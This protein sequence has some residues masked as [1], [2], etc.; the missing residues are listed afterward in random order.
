MYR[1]QKKRTNRLRGQKRGN[2]RREGRR[3]P[4]LEHPHEEQSPAQAAQLVHVHGDMLLLVGK[5]ARLRWVKV[6]LNW[7]GWLNKVEVDRQICC[8]FF[9]S[10]SRGWF[11]LCRKEKEK[12]ND[13]SSSTLYSPSSPRF[14]HTSERNL[15]SFGP[16]PRTPD[17][18]LQTAGPSQG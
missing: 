15:P 3:T 5:V 2:R 8:V 16:G 10:F 12:E 17:A 9:K 11:S 6:G 13:G 14:P 1:S 7:T 4:Q 18:I